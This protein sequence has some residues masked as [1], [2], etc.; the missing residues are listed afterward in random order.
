MFLHLKS[1]SSFR[2]MSSSSLCIPPSIHL[3]S[4]SADISL[5]HTVETHSCTPFHSQAA[6]Q[7]SLRCLPCTLSPRHL[8]TTP[9]LVHKVSRLAPSPSV[10]TPA[11]ADT[12]RQHATQGVRLCG[13]NI[14]G[15]AALCRVSSVCLDSCQRSAAL[16]SVSLEGLTVSPLCSTM[17]NT[18][19]NP[20]RPPP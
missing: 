13:N 1:A 10:L 15:A 9:K 18:Y 3:P 17:T 5:Q 19:I 20:Q 2:F 16:L 11:A 4:F 14:K 7:A 6:N 8:S 12:T